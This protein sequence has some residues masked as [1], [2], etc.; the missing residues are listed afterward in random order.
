MEL[1]QGT[2]TFLFTDI[3]GST[4]LWESQPDTMSKSVEIHDRII[5]DAITA[6]SGHHLLE[7]GEGDSHFGVFALAP[8]GIQC[9]L[10]IQ[11]LMSEQ[12]W[13]TSPLRVRI[14]IH[15]GHAQVRGKTYFGPHVNRAARIRAVGHGGQTIVSNATFELSKMHLR[16]IVK[17]TYLGK[18]RLKDLLDAEWLQQVEGVGAEQAFPPLR[19]LEH[20]AHNLPVQL[21]DFVG[22]RKDILTV[23]DLVGKRR[24]TTLTGA[25]GAGK[26]RLALQT[27]AELVDVI[28]GGI[29]F[30]DLS[31]AE[32]REDIELAI[33]QAAISIHGPDFVSKPIPEVF[34]FSPLLIILDN[35]E[36]VAAAAAEVAGQILQT[37]P[38]VTILATSREPLK[39]SGE[40]LYR[41]PPLSFPSEDEEAKLSNL[42]LYE[43]V[44]LF[45]N[46]CAELVPE[47]QWTDVE[48]ATIGRICRKLDGIP[49]ALELAASRAGI[50]SPIQIEQ[51]LSARLDLLTS[52]RSGVLS[53]YQTMRAAIDHSI[54]FLEDEP[55]TCLRY[56]AELQ[57]SVSIDLMEQIF[58]RLGI[59]DPL[60]KVED[61]YDKSLV[62]VDGAFSEVRYR[63]LATIREFISE[64]RE[65]DVEKFNRA[66]VDTMCDL[67]HEID[68]DYI[69]GRQQSAVVRFSQEYG[70]LELALERAISSGREIE[71]A[72]LA[73]SLHRFW[74][75]MSRIEDGL[76][77]IRVVANFQLDANPELK[78]KV[79]N[80]AGVFEWRVEAY[81][82]A[83]ANFETSL[84]IWQSLNNPNQVAAV[85]NNL[86]MLTG[87]EGDEKRAE[88][89]FLSSI[90]VARREGDKPA[91]ARFLVNLGALKLD[92][93]R[94]EEARRQFEEAANVTQNLEDDLGMANL[95]VNIAFAAV[96]ARSSDSC[97]CLSRALKFLSEHDAPASTPRLLLALA[98]EL[99]TQECTDGAEFFA[100]ASSQ[101]QKKHPNPRGKAED[102]LANKVLELTQPHQHHRGRLPASRDLCLQGIEWLDKTSDTL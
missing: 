60:S 4:G 67:A 29:W 55:A 72:T 30:V 53:R 94:Y 20:V 12:V 35:C 24:L 21:A 27:A 37:A 47:K 99:A 6:H 89:Y 14:G 23:R 79:S 43:S 45:T 65:C 8:D 2:V 59:R 98:Y 50:L 61:L 1:P 78:A 32:S 74:L 80:V 96:A 92:C 101:L 82:K 49:L 54:A 16:D 19:T 71:A 31:R 26:T 15:T 69:Q 93:G 66:L 7:Q 68:Q 33:M 25:G 18:H 86:G 48:I 84:E 85:L 70:N 40:Q 34:G 5:S 22:R 52:N 38:A 28:S 83:R 77:Y 51:R 39:L 57:S 73:Y 46:R 17:F 97:E 9:A 102:E 11:R 91:L 13:P 88:E 3:E 95:L 75:H 56:L 36:Q 87:V 42:D 10:Q 100:T 90:E 64:K 41:V 62:V 44:V 58:G 63:L 76:K 81:G